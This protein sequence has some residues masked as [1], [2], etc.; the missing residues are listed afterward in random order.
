MA[1]ST[2]E[3]CALPFAGVLWVAILTV[4]FLVVDCA[5]FAVQF[6]IEA[7]SL[8]QRDHAVAPGESFVDSD[9]CKSCFEPR[10]FAAGQFAATDALADALLFAALAVVDAARTRH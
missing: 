5:A 7:R 3:N 9:S 2:V 4:V 10:G 1:K 6:A 8:T